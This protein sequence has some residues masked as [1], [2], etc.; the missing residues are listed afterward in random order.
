MVHIKL[1][2]KNSLQKRSGYSR[3]LRLLPFSLC[4]LEVTTCKVVGN[5]GVHARGCQVFCWEA[6]IATHTLLFARAEGTYGQGSV[7]IFRPTWR[8][9]KW[10]FST[11]LVLLRQFHPL[12]RCEDVT[13]VVDPGSTPVTMKLNRFFFPP[14]V[15]RF[16]LFRGFDVVL[17]PFLEYFAYLCDRN[18]ARPATT[19]T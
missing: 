13:A 17:A 2:L 3:L 8:R 11:K 4:S 19:T 14:F 7:D 15:H 5:I 10:D 16:P 18:R 9:E 1:Q 6:F 12:S